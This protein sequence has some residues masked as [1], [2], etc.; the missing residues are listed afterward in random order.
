MRENNEPIATDL[1]LRVHDGA[2]QN[3]ADHRSLTPRVRVAKTNNERSHDACLRVVIPGVR[4]QCKTQ[5]DGESVQNA[6]AVMQD[7]DNLSAN[8]RSMP[9]Q[10]DAASG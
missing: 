4:A 6:S 5:C 3:G 8:A 1:R 10:G 7:V 2:T 9:V